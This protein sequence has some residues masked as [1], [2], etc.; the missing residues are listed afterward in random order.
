MLL[1]EGFAALHLR[2]ADRVSRLAGIEL[3][4]ALRHWTPAGRQAAAAWAEVGFAPDARWLWRAYQS[5]P[6]ARTRPTFGCFYQTPTGDRRVV[7]LH[8]ANVEGPGVLARDRLPIRRRE[9]AR[10]LA[11]ARATGPLPDLL[12]GGS[13]LYHLAPYRTLFPPSFLAS[14]VP[15]DSRNHLNSRSPVSFSGETAGF[16]SRGS[17]RSFRPL[18]GRPLRPSWWPRSRWPGSTCSGRSMMSSPGYRVSRSHRFSGAS[19]LEAEKQFRRVNGYRD[20]QLLRLALQATTK[21][22]SS[23]LVA[24]VA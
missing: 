17:R 13:W 18:S 12:R 8:F 4:D 10:M 5:G 21:P 9:L 7:R 16:T 19:V 20:L 24:T 15:A 14:A 6:I 2:F 11:D 3:T 23:A 22:P 1:S